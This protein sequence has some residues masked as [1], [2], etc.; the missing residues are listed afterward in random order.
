MP[1]FAVIIPAAGS[2]TRFGADKLRIR[3]AGKDVLHWAIEA[4]L[5]RTDVVSLVIPSRT[6]GFGDD[7]PTYADLIQSDA[8]FKWAAGGASRAESV[9]SALRQ[10]PDPVEWVAVHDGA[11]PLVSQALIDRTLAAAVRYGAAVPAMPVA[12]TIKQAA[13]P[14]PARV[15]RTIPRAGLWAMQTPQV[16][17]RA[18]LLA[19]FESCPIPLAQVTDDV[20]LIEL[21]GKD[22]YLVEGEERN[23]KITTP[24]D[25][26]VAESWIE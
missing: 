14:L 4:F 13:G 5:S 11:R 19:A 22:V 24:G 1:D 8:R 16:M 23:I 26:R 15:E 21:A 7:R 10:V 12:L 18:D 25:I 2:S 20:Q 3:L 9:F 6:Q 17:R